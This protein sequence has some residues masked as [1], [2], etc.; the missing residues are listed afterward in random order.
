MIKKPKANQSL[1]WETLYYLT[2]AYT[3]ITE[4]IEQ[5]K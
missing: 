4:G 2:Q 1:L 3:Q 5:D